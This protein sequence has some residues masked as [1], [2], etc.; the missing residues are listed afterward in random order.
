MGQLTLL[1]Q[2]STS[3]R[4]GRQC[5]SCR[6]LK[7]LWSRCDPPSLFAFTGEKDEDLELLAVVKS[8]HRTSPQGR[9]K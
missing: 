8:L 4:F 9:T 3:W 1:A 6:S 7:S 2:L 5:A